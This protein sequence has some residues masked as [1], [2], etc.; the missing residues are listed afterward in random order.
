MDIYIWDGGYIQYFENPCIHFSNYS[1]YLKKLRIS[2]PFHYLTDNCEVLIYS[3]KSSLIYQVITAD[4][5]IVYGTVYTNSQTSTERG[6]P[7]MKTNQSTSMLISP[8]NR[9]TYICFNTISNFGLDNDLSPARCQAIT[10]IWLITI[11]TLTNKI[12]WHFLIEKKTH[13]IHW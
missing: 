11:W 4:I 6:T 1:R 2:W 3:F 9:G 7:L 5:L 8:W 13:H 12:Q 10:R